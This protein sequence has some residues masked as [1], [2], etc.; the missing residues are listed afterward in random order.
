V[1]PYRR[2]PQA[3]SVFHDMLRLGR[4]LDAA[5]AHALGVVDALVGPED[6]LIASAVSRVGELSGTAG[7]A[8]DL[9]GPVEIPAPPELDDGAF[10]KR[11]LSR[12]VI[13]IIDQAVAAAAK[14]DSFDAALEIG[15]AAFG[16]TACTEAA[17]EG[18]TAFLEKRRPD[19]ARTG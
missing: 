1:V 5:R 12:E 8:A 7:S 18:V 17:R 15:Y 14:A 9:D 16:A 13:G 4:K 19:F 2:W 11:P 3:A 6:D 10:G